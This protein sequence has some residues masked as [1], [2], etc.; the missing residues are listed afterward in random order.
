MTQ[1]FPLFNTSFSSRLLSFTYLSA[2]TNTC[3]LWSSQICYNC[4]ITWRRRINTDS[5]FIGVR[6]NA[7]DMMP[8]GSRARKPDW[9]KARHRMAGRIDF[10]SSYSIL[11]LLGRRYQRI[12]SP[13]SA[14]LPP[15]FGHLRWP[16]GDVG[17]V[18]HGLECVKRT[19][20]R[21]EMCR[22]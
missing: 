22:L 10:I 19:E 17:C 12:A 16:V 20:W 1:F 14:L 5:I 6:N 13:G 7:S 18:R 9:T 2:T 11:A 21:D 8:K 3:I 4:T 15:H